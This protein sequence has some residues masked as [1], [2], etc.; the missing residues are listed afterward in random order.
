M[1]KVAWTELMAR[2]PDAHLLVASLPDSS[3]AE[4]LRSARSAQQLLE[5]LFR[6]LPIAGEYAV[7]VS[8]RF[9]RREIV[10]AFGKASDADVAAQASGASPAP[11]RHG[12]A[13]QH[14]LVLNDM[15]EDR[16]LEIAGKAST[17]RA[18]RRP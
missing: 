7:M 2:F 5:R 16:I 4:K 15:A 12:S 18:A 14:D 6:K 11:P 17:R 9:G 10:C 8:R 1:P 13:S 3:D